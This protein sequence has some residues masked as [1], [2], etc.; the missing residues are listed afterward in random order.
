[1]ADKLPGGGR[2]PCGRWCLV[3]G[4]QLVTCRKYLSIKPSSIKVRREPQFLSDFIGMIGEEPQE[5]G[6]HYICEQCNTQITR[7]RQSHRFAHQIKEQYMDTKRKRKE[8]QL[9]S[10]S[11]ASGTPQAQHKRKA[12]PSPAGTPSPRRVSIY[13][14]LFS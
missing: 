13:R 14:F 10:Q 12:A 5:S 7:V 11:P 4:K 9:S 6:S 8:R 1:M 3:C 2:Q